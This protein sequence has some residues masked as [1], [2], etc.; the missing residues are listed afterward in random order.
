MISIG[1][2]E[3]CF[4]RFRFV[5]P[6]SIRHDA[7]LRCWEPKCAFV[8]DSTNMLLVFNRTAFA[9]RSPLPMRMNRIRYSEKWPR[10][11][12]SALAHPSHGPPGHAS[13]RL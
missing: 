4:F 10:P 5:R 6:A 12:D 13:V 7:H 8:R 3:L 11:G 1:A 9:E 2:F